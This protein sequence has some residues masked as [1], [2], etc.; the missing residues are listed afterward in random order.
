MMPA[1][2]S[3]WR[4]AFFARLAACLGMF[5][6]L[7]SCSVVLLAPLAD[8][9]KVVDFFAVPA[10]LLFSTSIIL[11]RWKRGATSEG[12]E[13]WHLELAATIGISSGLV[14]S[15]LLILRSI[16]SYFFFHPAS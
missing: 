3:D 8:N 13:Q 15:L 5:P 11:G 6:L 16:S 1:N 14:L 4:R 9:W 10:L 7:F 2:D 12:G